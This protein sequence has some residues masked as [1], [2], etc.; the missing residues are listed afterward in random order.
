MII[1][2]RKTVRRHLGYAADFCPICGCARAFA[3]TRVGSAGHIYYVTAGDGD[4][5]GFERACL[6]C[7]TALRAEP[8][9]YAEMAKQPAAINALLKQTFPNFADAYKDRLALEQAIRL[10][11]NMINAADRQELIMTPFMLLSVR[12]SQRFADMHFTSSTAFM[13][14]EILPILARGLRRLRPTDA[15]LKAALTRLV[16][17]K[18][19]IGSKV[20]LADLKAEL[21]LPVDNT[22]NGNSGADPVPGKGGGYAP[23]LVGDEARPRANAGRLMRGLA[24]LTGA[25]IALLGLMMLVPTETPKQAP[26]S[27]MVTMLVA[28]ALAYGVYRAGWAVTRGQQWGRTAGIVF[29]LL[30][31]PGFP[32]ST[33]FGG[34]LLWSLV[35][36]WS[37][38]EVTA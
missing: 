12:V 1:W 3:L 15:E 19:M 27:L 21:N 38:E 7:T 24:Y 23:G 28:A 4:L 9:R 32:I 16:Q 20:K 6:V 37:G 10:D 11:P 25:G 2:G 34:Y 14:R 18:E 30:L 31:L 26:A 13:K 35:L 36:K 33:V 8:T 17:L 29:G 5:V 22:A